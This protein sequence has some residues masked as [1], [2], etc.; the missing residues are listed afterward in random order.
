MQ[1]K[2]CIKVKGKKGF[3]LKKKLIQRGVRNGMLCGVVI[4]RLTGAVLAQGC[5]SRESGNLFPVLSCW[6]V[7]HL[8]EEG[9]RTSRND[10]LALDSCFNRNDKKQIIH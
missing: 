2:K 7:Q 10:R 5:H 9:F 8:S 6:L 3:V 1:C 4:A